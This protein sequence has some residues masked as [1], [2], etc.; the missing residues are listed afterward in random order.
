M[1]GREGRGR[2]WLCLRDGPGLYRR[3]SLLIL[4]SLGRTEE[5]GAGNC[6]SAVT[7]CREAPAGSSRL[8]AQALG[9]TGFWDWK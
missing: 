2:L 4:R 8:A 1:A 6:Y 3:E 7:H 9:Q 5:G